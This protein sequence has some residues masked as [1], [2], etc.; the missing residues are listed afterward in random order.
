MTS[1]GSSRIVESGVFEWPWTAS[2]GLLVIG[3]VSGGGG[4]GGGALCLEGLNLYGAGGGGGGGGGGMTRVGHK[5]VHYDASGGNGGDGGGGGGL[6]EGTPVQGESGKG[7]SYGHG[8]G[9]G[10]G[11]EATPSEGRVVAGGGD[12]G[13]GF[14]GEVK[15]IEVSHLSVGDRFEIEIGIGGR[16][17]YA[18]RGYERGTEGVTGAG[19]FVLL[20]PVYES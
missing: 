4:G 1:T 14:P 5:G 18:G 20:V 17:G 7:G 19:G 9:G 3:G 12:G 16:G 13:R 11:A 2:H 15:V 10:A 8:G 6:R